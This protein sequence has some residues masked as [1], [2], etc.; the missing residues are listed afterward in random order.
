MEGAG[1]EAEP[2]EPPHTVPVPSIEDQDIPLQS[3]SFRYAMLAKLAYKKKLKDKRDSEPIVAN[4][5]LGMKLV[6][7]EANATSL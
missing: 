2:Y 1:R 7:P 5:Y 4:Y 3:L 6:F